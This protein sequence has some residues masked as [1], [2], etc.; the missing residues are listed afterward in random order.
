MKQLGTA[1]WRRFLVPVLLLGFDALVSGGCITLWIVNRLLNRQLDVYAAARSMAAA[2]AIL[3]FMDD[4]LPVYLLF[5]GALFAL[6]LS[7]VAVWTW[8]TTRSRLLRY[9]V[10]LL[11]LAMLVVLGGLWILRGTAVPAVP[12][13]TPT[14][15]PA[16]VGSVLD[17]MK[18]SL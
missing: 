16:L 14:P 18:A 13:M 10:V 12:P 11:C 15:T 9:A 17:G 3:D 7:T 2:S 1:A 6:L 8:V 5:A 4:L